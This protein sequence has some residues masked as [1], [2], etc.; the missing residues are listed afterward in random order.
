MKD[1]IMSPER[2]ALVKKAYEHWAKNPHL[3]K[4]ELELKFGICKQQL[5]F[6]MMKNKKKRPDGK[7]VGSG[8]P[9]QTALK[10]AYTKAL[11]EGQTLSWALRYV[12]TLSSSQITKGDLRYY[13]QKHNLAELPDETN[14]NARNVAE[15]YRQ[16]PIWAKPN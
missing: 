10:E 4:G 14:P 12:N 11:K 16:I 3:M 15:Q 6:W 13:Q 2:V 8:S 7:V 9:R 1:K 5:N